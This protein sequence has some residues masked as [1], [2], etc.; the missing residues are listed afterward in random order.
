[1]DDGAGDKEVEQAAVHGKEALVEHEDS[2]EGANKETG[3]HE[4]AEVSR[5][6]Q[7]RPGIRR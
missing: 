1:M 6:A 2:N 7:K 3:A 5:K 4:V